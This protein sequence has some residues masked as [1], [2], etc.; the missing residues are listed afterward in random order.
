MTEA[1]S[2]KTW[3]LAHNGIYHPSK[4]GKIRVMFDLSAIL[5]VQVPKDQC[6]FL[7][8]LWWNNS[9]PEKEII[10]YEMTAHIWRNIITI[11]LQ[12]Y[13]EENSKRQ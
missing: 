10:D 4:P 2:G 13:I 7:K 5:Q 9:D 6:S 8:F 3:Y 12:F 11:L 1:A